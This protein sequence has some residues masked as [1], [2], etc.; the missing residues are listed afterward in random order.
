MLKISR[1]AD[2]ASRV[3]RHMARYGDE[4]FSATQI[5]ERTYIAA[6][7]VRK[8]L[9]QLQQAQLLVSSRGKIGG[10]QLGQSPEY[11]SLAQIVEAID[12]PIALTSCSLKAANCDHTQHCQ[13]QTDWQLV[14][15]TVRES[16][17]KITLADLKNE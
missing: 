12:G 8:I 2:Y 1:L 11:I 14:N 5:A 4:A 15:H 7:T 13:M 9:K 17:A 3:M 6:P 16:L 10:Y